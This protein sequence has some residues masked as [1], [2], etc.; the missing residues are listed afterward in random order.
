MWH[1][2]LIGLGCALAVGLGALGTAIVQKAIGPAVVGAVMED[3]KFLGKGILLLAI[4]ETMVLLG[5]VI[6]YFMLG[7]L[8]G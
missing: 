4:T 7:K 1:L 5:F 3:K 8:S 6:A 2:G